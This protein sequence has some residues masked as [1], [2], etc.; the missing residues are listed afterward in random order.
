MGA[1]APGA[2]KGAGVALEARAEEILENLW[3][4]TV[5]EGTAPVSPEAL[6]LGPGEPDLAGLLEQGLV[7]LH[8]QGVLL[9]EAGLREAEHVVR[10]HRLAERLMTDVLDMA[11]GL[12]DESACQ[13]EHLLRREVEEKVCTLLGHPASCPHGKPIPPGDCCREERRG[14]LKWVRPLNALK[15][16]QEGRIAYLHMGD[17]RRMQ[18]LM[19]MGV[20]PGTSVRLIRRFPSF[21]FQ[22]SYSRFAVDEDM[23]RGIYV[24]LQPVP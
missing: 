17:P 24:R 19:A 14:E 15:P 7:A 4:M 18:K 20:L 22:M 2:A 23:A 11:E 13:F 8:G 21:I 3:R 9:Q 16:G 6:G 5:E 12:V 10:R 1:A